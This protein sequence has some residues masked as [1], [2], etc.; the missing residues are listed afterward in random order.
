MPY[1]AKCQTARN[2]RRRANCGRPTADGQLRTANSERRTAATE[3]KRSSAQQ[4][5]CAWEG[6][7]L[8]DS[9]MAHRDLNVLDAAQQAAEKVNAL[10]DR[11]PQR[12]LHVAQM[13]DSVQSICANIA[14]GFGRGKGRDRARPLEIARGET[15]ETIQHLGAN[16]RTKRIA[17]E[18]YWPVHNLLV[19]IVK[20][21]NSLLYR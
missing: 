16:F 15:E 8:H 5:G 10:I 2:A 12:L 20:M 13:R 11:S 14:E 7:T 1:C 6:A 3:R 4:C 21:L 18:D 19:V 17:P 9:G